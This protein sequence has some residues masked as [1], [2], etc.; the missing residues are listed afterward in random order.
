MLARGRISPELVESCKQNYKRLHAAVLQC[1]QNEKQLLEQ[2]R[3]L[4]ACLEQERAQMEQ[5]IAESQGMQADID[6]L[7][8]ESDEVATVVQTFHNEANVCRFELE[9]LHNNIHD[10][11]SIRS[12]N[13]AKQLN[14]L[15]PVHDRLRLRLDELSADLAKHREQAAQEQ[16]Q[17]GRYRS[18]TDQ[19][20][21][22]TSA[23][24]H[25]RAQLS[26]ELEAVAGGRGEGEGGER[27]R[28]RLSGLE[29]AIRRVQGDTAAAERREAKA[30][31]AVER[32]SEQL[33]AQRAQV[34][35][36]AA[37]CSELS[38][39]QASL[40]ALAARLLGEHEDTLATI[41]ELERQ[42]AELR[43]EQERLEGERKAHT[44]AT[45]ALQRQLEQDRQQQTQARRRLDRAQ[46]A[47]Q[48]LTLE[49][50][51]HEDVARALDAELAAQTQTLASLRADEE[52]F[53]A[54]VLQQEQLERGARKAVESALA[55]RAAVE[56]RVTE[57]RG[58][59]RTLL[60]RLSSLSG[61]RDGMVRRLGETR[62][63]LA[64]AKEALR[65]RGRLLQ[66]LDHSAAD[67][68]LRVRATTAQLEH[69]TGDQ[70]RL[71]QLHQR[72]AMA[73]AALHTKQLT[74]ESEHQVAA[75]E[76]A[77][78]ERARKSYEGRLQG[79]SLCRDQAKQDRAQLLAARKE[80]SSS[81]AR[82]AADLVALVGVLRSGEAELVSL[83][84]ALVNTA[85]Q[86]TALAVR[87]IDRT[88]E[89]AAAEAQ[90]QAWRAVIAKGCARV[91][92]VEQ[93]LR[94]VRADVAHVR[95][96]VQ[97]R[98]RGLPS[99]LVYAAAA[100]R[101]S[102]LEAELRELQQASAVL[103]ARLG[104]GEGE[105]GEAGAGRRCRVLGGSDLDGAA[106]AE[107]AAA[108]EATVAARE[109]QAAER[110]LVLSALQGVSTGL[111]RAA[112]EGRA[113]AVAVCARVNEY[114]ARL[115]SVGRLLMGVVSE[116]SLWQ[117]TGARLQGA[118]A[119]AE[120][121]VRV[122]R[123]RHS[124]G[125]PPTDDAHFEWFRRERDRVV[126]VQALENR[127]AELVEQQ[128]EPQMRTAAAPRPNHYLGEAL[129]LPKP[130]GALAPFKAQPSGAAARIGRK[131]K[132]REVTL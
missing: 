2:A 62:A 99:L 61:E 32:L 118:R 131:P 111:R 80:S 31:E 67:V 46:S 76:F 55:E 28:Q 48:R 56:A 17:A 39:G 97:L 64:T 58:T 30:D 44:Q 8:Q 90:A 114:R 125:K 66:A 26:G 71:Q 12:Q 85:D 109:E 35:K 77:Q 88:D 129:A 9:E 100:Q 117:A 43:V 14:E 22:Q 15:A 13:V 83:R 81:R 16:E 86:R 124:Q 20:V 33:D 96:R 45:S 40:E 27:Q 98:R 79:L 65:A 101:V 68:Y 42:A 110:E 120:E 4:A 128:Q 51:E 73:A 84:A 94:S 130:Y 123:Q 95:G 87:V 57:L 91:R 6:Q 23:L 50:S 53:T 102:R 119:E 19:L 121:A 59:E 75:K 11:N 37:V 38:Q 36:C 47:K 54:Q 5:R 106:L 49:L 112:G 25:T 103:G 41:E 105:P 122:A 104:G 132:P 108:L 24:E 72:L 107:K 127:R 93:Q 69:V 10:N 7:Q 34:G 92:A 113:E 18:K 74:L 115:R 1:F 63:D 21:A 70:H 52:L 78:A 29:H 89:L 60:G 116:L 3:D 126:R 82:A